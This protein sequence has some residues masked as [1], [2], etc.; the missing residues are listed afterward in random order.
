MGKGSDI[1]GHRPPSFVSRT[2]L[3]AEL[4]ISVSTLDNYVQRGLLPKPIKRGAFLRWC[5]AEVEADLK[6]GASDRDSDPFMSGVD[7][8]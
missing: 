7:S 6:R 5:W 2:T 8:V 1:T 4:D 3:A